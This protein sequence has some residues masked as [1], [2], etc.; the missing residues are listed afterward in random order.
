MLGK[1]R[2]QT[3]NVGLEGHR[4]KKKKGKRQK[5]CIPGDKEVGKKEKVR[6]SGLPLLGVNHERNKKET[7]NSHQTANGAR[8]R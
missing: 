6:R 8:H 7:G 4:N 5:A 2:G 3:S 1:R